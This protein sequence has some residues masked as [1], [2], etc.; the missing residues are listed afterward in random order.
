MEQA[1]YHE[2]KGKWLKPGSTV[3]ELMQIGIHWKDHRKK[4]N[5]KI[6]SLILYALDME[7]PKDPLTLTKN[8]QNWFRL[9]CSDHDFSC[10]KIRSATLAL[11]KLYNDKSFELNGQ[12]EG[13]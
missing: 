3:V 1:K 6:K 9:R 12:Q 5:N 13:R 4:N 10:Q 8:N 7:T 11:L 2:I